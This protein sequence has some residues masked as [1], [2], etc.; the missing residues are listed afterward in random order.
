MK[1]LAMLV[2]YLAMMVAAQFLVGCSTA[3]AQRE[4][5]G[6]ACGIGNN[7]QLY[8]IPKR[9]VCGGREWCRQDPPQP[10]QARKP[11]RRER[12]AR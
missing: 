11:I 1:Y 8:R 10:Q 4:C 3:N 2:A 12:Q 5:G 9:D 7:G 6:H